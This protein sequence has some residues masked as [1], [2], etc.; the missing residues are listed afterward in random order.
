MRGATM[1]LF[2]ISILLFFSSAHAG[3]VENGK[4]KAETCTRCHGQSGLSNNDLWP[5]LAG[6]RES[7]ILKQLKA[8]HDGDRIDPVMGPVSKM[9]NDQD[10]QDLAAY[11]SQL[12][13]A[14]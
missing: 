1:P 12:K 9:L 5:N 3:D 2:L 6:Q 11:F 10:M 7:Y 4:R 8:F 13:G 14:Q